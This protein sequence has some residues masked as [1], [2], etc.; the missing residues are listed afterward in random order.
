VAAELQETLRLLKDMAAENRDNLKLNL[1]KIKELIG[2]MEESLKLLNS[3]LE[4]INR[5]EGTLG[6]II[7]DP[8]LYT[9]AK[10]T[11]DD[12]RKAARPISSLRGRLD[13]RADYYGR[14]DLVKAGVMAGLW[15]TPNF[16]AEAGVVRNPWEKTFMFS[17]AVG[18]RWGD[19]V[20]R[21]GFIESEFGVGL[22]Y[23]AINDRWSISLEGFDF[24]RPDSPHYRVFSRFSPLKYL[25]LV[26]GLDDFSLA[27]RRGF[28]FGLGLELR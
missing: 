28:F 25:Y 1:E 18:Y 6:K 17:L 8:E 3:S 19:L 14:S 27:S 20:P 26:A 13:L 15:L 7:Q 11:L 4:K 12:V 22:D 2:K 5:G 10:Q 16:F 23:Y 21:A 24:N 9:K